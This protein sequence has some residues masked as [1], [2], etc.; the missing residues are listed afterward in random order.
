MRCFID[1]EEIIDCVY[2]A[3]D[4]ENYLQILDKESEDFRRGANFGMVQAYVAI[5]SEC[6]KYMSKEIN[7]EGEADCE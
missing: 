5:V 6:K 7:N 2:K 1:I 4:A 3:M